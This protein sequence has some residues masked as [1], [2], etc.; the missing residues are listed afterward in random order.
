[1]ISAVTASDSASMRNT[2]L[3]GRLNGTRDDQSRPISSI[4]L[5]PSQRTMSPVAGGGQGRLGHERPG[6]GVLG[7][8]GPGGGTPPFAATRSSVT[9]VVWLPEWKAAA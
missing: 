2:S 1:A 9:V 7:L 3:S 4:H 5:A 8:A 6:A